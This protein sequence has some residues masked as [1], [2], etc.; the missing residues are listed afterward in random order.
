MVE[1]LTKDDIEVKV[2]Q[3]TAK[4][5][6]LLLYKTARV[7][8]AML[9]K[10]YGVG[11]WQCDYKVVNNNLYCGIGVLVNN[12]WVW[13]WDCGVESREDGEGNEK[14]GE[15]SDAFKRAGFKWGIGRELYTAP[16]IWVNVPT[17]LDESKST[18]NKKI[19]KLVNTYEKFKVS[20]IE[21]DSNRNISFLEIVDSKND[22]VFPTNKKVNVNKEFPQAKEIKQPT[23]DDI[24]NIMMDNHYESFGANEFYDYYSKNNWKSKTG[25]AITTENVGEALK[26]WELSRK[27]EFNKLAGKG[28]KNV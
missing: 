16:F 6:L 13:K 18:N 1:L 22:I 14:K 23:L 9:D 4:G 19:Y 8:M 26:R 20:K 10:I 11:N 25:Q 7:D 12:N 5:C 3:I 2:K 21:Y 24:K 28:A 15:A 27:D 17:E